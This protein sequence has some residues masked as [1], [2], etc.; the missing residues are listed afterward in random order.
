MLS[1][2]SR[3]MAGFGL[4][5]LF[6]CFAIAASLSDTVFY[7]NF[8]EDFEGR[9]VVSQNSD[10]GGTWKHAKSDGHDDYGLL[11]SEKAK[12]YGIAVDLPEKVDPK[13]GSLVLQYDLRLQ[14]GLEC[15]GAYLKFLQPQ[16]A[17]WTAND[18][19]NE[20]PY[21]IMFG[22]DK[23]GATN[24]VHFIF[25]H[26]NPTTGKYVEHHLKNPPVPAGD[27]LS[28]VYTAIIYPNNT[29]RILIDGEE[30]KTADLL[31]EEFEPTVIPA[32][33]I[34]DPEDKKPEDWDDR[35]KIPDPDAT[36]P[37]DWDEDAPREIEDEEAEKP[38]GWLDDE[39]D[40]VDDP[41][42]VKPEDWDDEEDGEWEPPKIT[43]PKCEEGPGCG[44]WKRPLKANP[45]Y[46]GKWRAPMI[47]NPAYQGIWAPRQIPNPEYFELEKLN[48]EAV[49]AIGIEIWTMQDGIFFDNILVA[50]DEAVAEEYRKTTWEPKH[51][52][53]KEKEAAEAKKSDDKADKTS[54][55]NIKE[56]VFE[57]L[58]KIAEVPFLAKYKEQIDAV[59]DKAESNPN[60]T[61][62]V[63]ATIPV[64]LFTMLFSLCLG[65]KKSPPAVTTGAIKKEDLV[66][67]DDVSVPKGEQVEEAEQEQAGEIEKEGVSARRRPR[68]E[69]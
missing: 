40:E 11:V 44:E 25:R 26:K 55:D 34:P 19:N 9:W 42:A 53:E 4:L 1:M 46:K 45:A 18:F 3:G 23:C 57:A 29:L 14:N 39:P 58:N 63:L 28:H 21:S 38:E 31:S 54:V 56:K 59:L 35:A 67:A 20:S 50:H 49:A 17:G 8:D 13:D 62:G 7:E 15:G 10:Y 52:V 5:V 30:K 66:T 6:A 16:E 51:T 60:V 69:T 22:P 43:N 64:L 27:K 32:K 41:E 47:D 33:T 68:R 37:D 24:K 48:L 61:L 65:K 36:K 12:K 2:A